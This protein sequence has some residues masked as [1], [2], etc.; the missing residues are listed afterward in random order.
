MC[1]AC[2]HLLWSVSA[3]PAKP[4][5]FRLSAPLEEGTFLRNSLRIIIVIIT[6]PIDWI[7]A[8]GDSEDP[9][10]NTLRLWEKQLKELMRSRSVR[11][12]DGQGL[13]D[14]L[15][16]PSSIYRQE[17]KIV[18]KQ[19]GQDGPLVVKFYNDPQMRSLRTKGHQ[20]AATFPMPSFFSKLPPSV[21]SFSTPTP[22]D[23]LLIGEGL[24][25]F[26]LTL[27]DGSGYCKYP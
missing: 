6:F 1:A 4:L 20:R 24:K 14:Y 17:E 13:F 22:N 23:A 3:K 26:V 8:P 7:V 2:L 18:A 11:V 5:E 15:C 12:Y 19:K 9:E 16:P 25:V 21:A 27:P 10:A